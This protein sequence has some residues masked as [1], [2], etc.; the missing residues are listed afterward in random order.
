MLM[1]KSVFESQLK[2]ASESKSVLPSPALW[3]RLETALAAESATKKVSFWPFKATF[4]YRAA[5]AAVL[6]FAAGF[7]WL[8]P[9]ASLA[10]QAGPNLQLV[11]TPELVIDSLNHSS[12]DLIPT[13]NNEPVNSLAAR[14]GG[15]PLRDN[16]FTE[17]S[18]TSKESPTKNPIIGRQLPSVKNIA[19]FSEKSHAV[20][21]QTTSAQSSPLAAVYETDKESV[22]LNLEVEN[23][24]E[25][26]RDF[27]LSRIQAALQET[28][29]SST[30][31]QN[32]LLEVEQEMNASFRSKV[33]EEIKQNIVKVSQSMAAR[34]Q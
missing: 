8:Q 24:L 11:V 31:A 23:L 2:K 34:N 29:N 30:D 18:N 14:G 5:A 22:R 13:T 20:L 6:V 26:Q 7:Y 27:Q 21:A 28:L 1:K 32:L 19:G 12:P 15:T 10:T 33:M 3:G 9:N 16:F 4:F 17:N 25:A